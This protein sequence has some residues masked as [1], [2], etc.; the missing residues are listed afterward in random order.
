MTRQAKSAPRG[1]SRERGR[2]GTVLSKAHNPS[3]VLKQPEKINLGRYSILAR[4]LEERKSPASVLVCCSLLA[5][6]FRRNKGNVSWC[7]NEDADRAFGVWTLVVKTVQIP[8]RQPRPG[9]M[10]FRRSRR[11]IILQA[12]PF[13]KVIRLF[14]SSR[15]GAGE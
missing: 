8:S 7:S 5:K 1:T 2:V 11:D 4:P 9:L 10:S 15:P 3:P 12:V 6:I 14:P 13:F